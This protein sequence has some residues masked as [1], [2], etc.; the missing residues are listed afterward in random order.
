MDLNRRELIQYA[1]LFSLMASTGLI[2]SVE[3]EEWNKAAFD[4]KNVDDVYRALGASAPEKSSAI[5]LIVPEL[6]ENGA[7]VP[8]TV[9]T[10]LKGQQ[11]AILVEKNPNALAGQFFLGPTSES[12]VTTR[13]KMAQSSN[14]FGLVRVESKWLVAIKEVKVTLGGCG[15]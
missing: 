11:I 1:G 5:N 10:D 8:V 7:L 3:A 13:I 2:S 4:A 12:F 9:S 15:S 6:S 14:V